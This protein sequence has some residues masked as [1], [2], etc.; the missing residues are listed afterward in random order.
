[1][2]TSVKPSGQVYY[3]YRWYV[4]AGVFLLSFITIV[5]RVAI[6]VS[7]SAMSRDLG[8]SNM[9]FGAVFGAFALGYAVLMVPS[10]WFADRLGPRRFLALTVAM[11]SCFTLGTGLVRT[12]APLMAVRFAF[13]MAEAGAYPT[14]TR[15]IYNWFPMRER[16]RALG[17][18][19]TGSRLGAAFGL[20]IMS[21]SVVHLGWRV[22]YYLLAGV[23]LLWA[24]VWFIWFRDRPPTQSVPAAESDFQSRPP[25]AKGIFRDLLASRNF[26]LILGQYFASNF[27]FFICFSWLL[28]YIQDRYHLSTSD[29][30]FYAGIP[31]YCGAL[32]TWLGGYLVDAIF[33]MGR[34]KMSR[35]L[36]AVLGFGLSAG[37]LLIA[38]SLTTVQGF[39]VCFALATLGVDLSLSS[40]WTTCA[41]VGREF[42]GTLSG[43]MN[44][45]GALGSFCSSLAFPFLL[46]ITGQP[47][48]YFLTAA[49]LNVLAILCWIGMHPDRP[50][51]K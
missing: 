24:G 35:V 1:M 31:L 42:T 36:P 16:G 19:N 8:I 30:G 47:Q 3:R 4:L 18:L 37:C 43:C 25:M 2:L 32:A 21:L 11:W 9:N 46:K 7:K 33:K 23:G 41:D 51:R 10:G 44:M 40:S 26:Y 15:A 29:A 39:I 38:G 45:A 50:L 28:P 49:A 14:A 12:L 5:D 6:S 20:A 27:T 34:W 48:T 13:G 17:L 22:S